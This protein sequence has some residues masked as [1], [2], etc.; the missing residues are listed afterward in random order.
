[1]KDTIE[2]QK[3]E[4]LK[5]LDTKNEEFTQKMGTLEDQLSEANSRIDGY[6]AEIERLVKEQDELRAESKKHLEDLQATQKLLN[7]REIQN[8]DLSERGEDTKGRHHEAT[9]HRW[10]SED[11][12]HTAV[13][14]TSHCFPS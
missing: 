14:L 10:H 11:T 12:V 7:E 6:K 2:T 13:T 3:R 1:M 5:E 8:A 4:Y 9:E